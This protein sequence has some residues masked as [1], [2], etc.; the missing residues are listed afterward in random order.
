MRNQVVP[1][2][3]ASPG[4]LPVAKLSDLVI[5]ES[6]EEVIVYDQ[7]SH[8]IHH[9]NR[10]SAVIWRSC[11]GTRTVSQIARSASAEL[12][13]SVDEDLVHVALAKLDDAH[14]FADSLLSS[15]RVGRQ[16]RRQVIKR[17]AVVG[18]GIA[19][20]PVITSITAPGA[21]AAFSAFCGQQ[22][23]CP[24]GLNSTCSNQIASCGQCGCGGGVFAGICVNPGH[25]CP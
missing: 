23:F 14:L 10:T 2:F 22:R 7:I 19:I 8:Q 12:G 17:M 13:V 21:A 24:D 5:T 4:M 6:G 1:P 20:V 25:D 16:S 15:S 11:D 3:T 9:L 18:G